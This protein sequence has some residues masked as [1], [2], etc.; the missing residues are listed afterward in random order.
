VVEGLYSELAHTTGSNGGFEAGTAPYADRVVDD[1]TV[2]HGWGGAEYVTLLRNMLVREQGS[3]IYLMSAVSPNWLGGGKRIR[4]A[5]APTLFGPVSF[6]L[7]STDRGATLRWSGPA[8]RLVWPV[9]YLARSVRARG[10]DR[11][12]G[13]IVLPGRSG[14]LH[15]RWRLVGTPPTYENTFRSLMRAYFNSANGN[16]RVARARSSDRENLPAVPSKPSAA[17]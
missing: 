13:V 10:L 12:N 7:T 11:R 17:P 16:A 15:V 4:V 2:P 5:G 1:T 8:T 3:S 14:V 9:P 6:T